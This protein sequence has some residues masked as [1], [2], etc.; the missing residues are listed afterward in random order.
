M[1][2]GILYLLTLFRRKLSIITPYREKIVY[3]VY[4]YR[5]NIP[6]LLSSTL[7]QEF[8]PEPTGMLQFVFLL[9]IYLH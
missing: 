4:F 7:S 6:F 1:Y 3:F 8:A 9:S 5:A 2:F